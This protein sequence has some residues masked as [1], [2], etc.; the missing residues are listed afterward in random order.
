ME[1]VYLAKDY[2]KEYK[3]YSGAKYRCN[4]STCPD[5]NNYGGRGIIF[6]FASFQAFMDCVGPRPHGRYS[7]DRIDVNGSY[8]DGNIRWATDKQQARNTRSNTIFTVDDISKPLSE[9]AEMYGMSYSSVHRR[10]YRYGWTAEKAL[11]TPMRNTGRLNKCGIK[12][13]YNYGDRWIIYRREN[14]KK[15][16]RKLKTKKKRGWKI[17]EK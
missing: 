15:I 5:F 8:E 11:K 7:I 6:K 2:P 4:A 13:L 16:K 14:G 12:Y 17:K 3:S 1:Y 10:I 9:L